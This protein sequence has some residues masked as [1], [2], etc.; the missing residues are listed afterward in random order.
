MGS[1]DQLVLVEML[2][3][4]W[5]S[6]MLRPYVFGFLAIYLTGAVAAWGWR[7]AV[8]FTVWAGGL[9]FAAE[10]SSTRIGV[11]F[12][13]YHYTGSTAGQELYLSNVP[14]FDPLSFTFLAYASLGLAAQLLGGGEVAAPYSRGR[15][16]AGAGA[17]LRVAG[18]TGVLMMWLDVVI[19]PLAVRGDRWFL[20]RIFYYPVPGWY[21]GVPLA[22]FAGW[23]V[24]GAAIA[25]GWAFFGSRVRGAP[26]AWGRGLPRH[27][28]QAVGLYYLLLVFNLAVTAAV[29]E[30]ALLWSGVL[31]H[32]PL[33]VA[34][35]CSLRSWKHAGGVPVR[36]GEPV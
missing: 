33:A 30:R 24:V 19:D 21:F 23:A 17:R 5:G 12:G 1:A 35:V 27:G 28:P 11:P 18:V 14:F 10:W 29:A 8:A 15:R 7:R 34:V 22:N 4:V 20:G 13:L 3:R 16:G 2:G 6:L 31:L 9:A 25:W 36:G 32:L 26:P